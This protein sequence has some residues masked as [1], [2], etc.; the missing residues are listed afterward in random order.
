ME[1]GLIDSLRAAVEAS[2]DDVHLRLHLAEL[3]LDG[4]APAERERAAA[5]LE[6]CLA[7]AGPLGMAKV[8]ARARDAQASGGLG[9]RFAPA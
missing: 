5:L 2:P 9:D 8:A 6:A 7:D 4:G 1:R 3:L